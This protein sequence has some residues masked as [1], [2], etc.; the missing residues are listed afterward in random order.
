M[1]LNTLQLK[2]CS[3][4]GS[5]IHDQTTSMLL[6]GCAG[7]GKTTVVINAFHNSG[8]QLAFCAFTNKATQVLRAA[9]VKFNLNIQVDFLTI[10]KLLGLEPRLIN[11]ELVF[12][13]DV[14]RAIDL[15]KYDVVIFDECSTI[16]KEL[17]AHLYHAHNHYEQQRETK[18]KF[19]FL[20][21][22]WQ[23][24]PVGEQTSKIFE[25]ATSQRWIVNK[26]SV[27]MRSANDKIRLL[28]HKLTEFSGLFKTGDQR[29]YDLVHNY[30]FD[31]IPDR[32]MY[33]SDQAQ[34]YREYLS[35]FYS[36]SDS[37]SDSKTA[38]QKADVCILTYSRK[39]CIKT[40]TAIQNLI[41]ERAGRDAA[42]EKV[43]RFYAGDRCVVDRPVLVYGLVVK[44][45]YYEFGTPTGA[46]LYNGEIFTVVSA[47]PANFKTAVNKPRFNN[48]QYFSGQLLTIKAGDQLYTVP[49]V[50]AA[51]QY[52]ALFNV[53]RRVPKAAYTAISMTMT[54]TMPVFDYGYCI[55]L[56]KSQGSEWRKVYVNL[57]SIR[58][59][60]LGEEVTPADLKLLFKATY[61]AVTRAKEE[62]V[63]YWF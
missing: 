34:F 55:T 53:K 14:E 26:L 17:V 31:L 10:H 3:T 20:G 37:G 48:G 58:Y 60:T 41:N 7:S 25:L 15:L 18:L 22:Y 21:D 6:L 33:R 13:Y 54:D 29:V 46:T 27:V 12:L 52:K 36:G 51:D 49:F 38:D 1:N 44:N 11:S 62:L 4:I 45:G 42:D 40:N 39:N 28:N 16:S 9:S 50:P 5:F 30:P 8:L 35:D 23:L 43:S 47:E 61:T 57:S 32:D 2:A 59:S 56:Y 63:L 19:I 24:P